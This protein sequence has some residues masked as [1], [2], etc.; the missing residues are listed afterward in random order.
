M[1]EERIRSK[2]GGSNISKDIATIADI[3][4]KLIFGIFILRIFINEGL[5]SPKSINIVVIPDSMKAFS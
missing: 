5:I 1:P 3:F 2:L 4:F